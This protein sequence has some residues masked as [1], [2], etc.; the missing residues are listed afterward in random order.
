ML[1]LPPLPPRVIPT[2]LLSDDVFVKTT[3][4]KNPVYIGDPLNTINLFNNFE[5]DEI[6][7][8]DISC[9]KNRKNVNFELIEMLGT[10]CWVPLSYGG[11]I[12]SIETARK[13]LNSGVEK[14]VFE[15]LFH[16]NL[17]KLKECID[18]FGSSS[19]V[20][21]L[22]VKKNFFGQYFLRTPNNSKD[23]QYSLDKALEIINAIGVGELIINNISRDGTRLGYDCELLQYVSKRT[24]CPIIALGGASCLKDFKKAIDS[25][26]SAAAAGS[27][28]IF[29]NNSIDSILIHFP[30]RYEIEN[31]FNREK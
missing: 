12:N 15:S 28:F 17:D 7:I 10:E 16:L 30:E 14:I 20:I 2:L 22:D 18:L 24:N 6:V 13:I 1:N 27:F 23:T 26:A 8:L 5:V 21:C 25:G 31:L 9:S 19:I 29:Q 4:F 11:G 3:K